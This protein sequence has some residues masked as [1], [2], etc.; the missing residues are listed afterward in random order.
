MEIGIRGYSLPQ[1]E[2]RDVILRGPI[3]SLRE[4]GRN[5]E[6]FFSRARGGG[7]CFL[8]IRYR[9]GEKEE[10]K[11]LSEGRKKKERK[12]HGNYEVRVCIERKERERKFDTDIFPPSRKM[13][14][15]M[16]RGLVFS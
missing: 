10:K 1:E 3:R 11:A 4:K 2:R 6:K 5:A 14:R 13:N 9:E 12:K 15:G 16:N 7:G 8:N